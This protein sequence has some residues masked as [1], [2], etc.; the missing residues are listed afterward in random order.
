MFIYLFVQLEQ[1]NTF[2]N[3]LEAYY[4]SRVYLLVHFTQHC[5]FKSAIKLF[6]FFFHKNE[7]KKRTFAD[8]RCCEDCATFFLS[9]CNKTC[10]YYNSAIKRHANTRGSGTS[11]RTRRRKL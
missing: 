8:I 2:I 5:D 4:T 10:T 6:S 1:V 9:M 3:S 7:H 11:A